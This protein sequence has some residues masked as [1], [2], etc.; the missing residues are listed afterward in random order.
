MRRIVKNKDDSQAKAYF[1]SDPVF[2]LHPFFGQRFADIRISATV[3]FVKL[4]YTR[5]Q[6]RSIRR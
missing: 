3:N 6:I 5:S 4:P 1:I 2:Q